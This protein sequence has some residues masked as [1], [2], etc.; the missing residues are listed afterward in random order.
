MKLFVFECKKVTNSLHY[1]TIHDPVCSVILFNAPNT[2][3][4]HVQQGNFMVHALWLTSGTC[5]LKKTL[6]YKYTALKSVRI[7]A[8]KGNTI[9]YACS[10]WNTISYLTQSH[11]PVNQV[12][13]LTIVLTK[14][15]TIVKFMFLSPF[16]AVVVDRLPPLAHIH[17][18]HAILPV[19]VSYTQL[20]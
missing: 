6:I 19:Y 5:A 14:W 18:N 20:F 2:I 17:L 15:T 3:M 8:L 9:V 1:V 13:Y 12:T 4:F 7:W 11:S 10:H 16:R